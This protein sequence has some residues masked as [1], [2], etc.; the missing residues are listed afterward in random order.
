MTLGACAAHAPAAPP[1]APVAP[2]PTAALASPPFVLMSVELARAA[3]VATFVAPTLDR[4]LATGIALARAA[5][6]LPLE[7]AAVRELALTQLGI[8]PEVGQ[9]LDLAGPISGAVVGFGG[10]QPIK[11]AFTFTVKDGVDFA[12]LAA[13]LGRVVGRHG[14]AFE[15]DTPSNGHAWFLP[16]GRTILFAESAEALMQAGNLALEARR[17]SPDDLSLVVFPE[18]LARALGTDVKSALERFL[19]EIDARAARGGNPLGTEGRAQLAD[20]VGMAADLETAEFALNLDVGKGVAI[21]ARLRA[22][23][24]SKLAELSSNVLTVPIDPLLF[25][26]NDA[27]LV[28]T[29]AFPGRTLDQIRRLRATLTAKEN[30]KPAGKGSPS[31]KDLAHAGQ[32]LD[33]LIDSLVG[34]ASM[35]G[36][37]HP[38][39]SAEIAYPIK[40]EAAG[41]KLQTALL[42]ADRGSVLAML[43]VQGKPAGMDVKVPVVRKE[44]VGKL[45]AV[46]WNVVF[47]LP[48]DKQSLMKKLLGGTGIDT[49]GAVIGDRLIVTMGVGAKARLAAMASAPKP[50]V[51]D[52]AK[53]ATAETAKANASSGALAEAA[54][55]AGPR[56]LYYYVDL[57]EAL[58][59]ATTLGGAHPDPRLRM[60][61]SALTK[62]IPVL[63]GV[64]GDAQGRVLTL[65]LTIPPSCLS[66]IGGVMG[67]VLGQTR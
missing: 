51:A 1:A 53:P 65:D 20:L 9:K 18:A 5:T 30:E 24:G 14:A 63:G 11:A 22:K 2:T 21:L 48:G 41:K 17:A 66:G 13:T 27:G 47:N 40:D 50:A 4:A 25:G 52:K 7:P 59:L 10:D 29:S 57:R 19:G 64:A 15:I 43:T 28:V 62:P 67:M 36:R 55:L 44:S 26:K 23:K 8:P 58:G 37:L 60:L 33:T 46:H 3:Q 45:S 31:K 61:S 49:Y 42:A 16:M 12:K 39:L 34:T 32:F 38:T 6:P 35:V 54:A 56:S